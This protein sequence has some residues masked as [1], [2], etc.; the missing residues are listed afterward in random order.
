MDLLPWK[1]PLCAKE[2][3]EDGTW[4]VEDAEGHLVERGLEKGRAERIA[5]VLNNATGLVDDAWS[6][7]RFW[8]DQISCRAD[9]PAIMMREVVDRLRE[10]LAATPD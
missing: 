8:D 10:R 2:E 9:P 1:L 3:T 6:V 4:Y 7:V 5:G